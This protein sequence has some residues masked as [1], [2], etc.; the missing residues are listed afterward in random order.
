MTEYDYVRTLVSGE[1]DIN[2]KI[3]SA[4]KTALPGKSFTVEMLATNAR[5]YFDIALSGADKTIL[6]D[7]VQA[8]IDVDF[9]DEYREQ[10]KTLTD[11]KTSALIEDGFTYDSVL[12]SQSAFAQHNWLGLFVKKADINYTGGKK[13]STM[14]GSQYS[15]PD[16]TEM[17]NFWNAGQDAK[18]A[19]YDSGRAIK[20]QLN[21]ATTIAAIDAIVDNR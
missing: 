16:Q 6:D 4:V 1:Y 3:H 21:A 7:T 14:D 18:E 19:H 9:V 15:I 17:T 12:F 13:V 8:Y 11:I 10:R 5:F 2:Q 20:L